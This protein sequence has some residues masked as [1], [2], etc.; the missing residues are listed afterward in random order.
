MRRDELKLCTDI[1]GEILGFLFKQRKRSDEQGKI[2]NC[3]HH[4]VETLCIAVLEVLIQTI[5]TLIDKDVKVFV[6]INSVILYLCI[7]C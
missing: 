7:F 1:M 6:S 3:I 5:L 2:N 4:D